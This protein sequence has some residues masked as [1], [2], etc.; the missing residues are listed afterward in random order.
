MEADD[1]SENGLA[2]HFSFRVVTRELSIV[3]P[4]D[5]EGEMVVFFFCVLIVPGGGEVKIPL[6]PDDV[7]IACW[8]VCDGLRHLLLSRC[9]NH[10]HEKGLKFLLRYGL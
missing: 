5:D 4:N 7:L 3:A 2:V 1:I 8:L 9:R 6:P 10:R